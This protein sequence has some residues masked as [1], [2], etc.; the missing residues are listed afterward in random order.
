M[1]QPIKYATTKIEVTRSLGEIQGIVARYGA[2]RF[3]TRWNRD[4]TVWGVRFAIA[5][6]EGELP[7]ALKTGTER[8]F[9]ILAEARGPRARASNEDLREQ[10]ER[11][12]WR[13]MKDL[14]EQLLLAVETGLFNLAAAFMAH[15]EVWD[16]A[17][18]ATVTMQEYLARRAR[19]LPGNR[20]LLLGSGSEVSK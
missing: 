11:I 15:V 7:V 1:R 8:I 20:G 13:Q 4:G 14:I 3:E 5:A 6:D 2:T 10:A 12:A 17:E 18:S 19:L 16:E 9:E